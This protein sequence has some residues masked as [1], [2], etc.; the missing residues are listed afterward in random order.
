MGCLGESYTGPTPGRL[1][2]QGP[3]V[4]TCQGLLV[5]CYATYFMEFIFHK[6][7]LAAQSSPITIIRDHRL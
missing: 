7:N 2:A 4:T 5:F 6:P 1:R 3:C